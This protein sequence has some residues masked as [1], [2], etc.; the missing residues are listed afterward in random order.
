LDY[1]PHSREEIIEML[2]TVGADSVGELIEKAIP[3]EALLE[4]DLNLPAPL[5][6]QEA[7]LLIEEL[8]QKNAPLNG[9]ASFLGAGVYN[10][11]IPA[12]VKAVIEKPEFFTAYTPYQPEVSQG[13]LASIFE[14]Q[15]MIC[16]LTGMDA[17]NASMYDGA[18]ATAEAV[19]MARRI[20]KKKG[21]GSVIVLEPINPFYLKVLEA[22][23][24]PHGIRIVLCPHNRGI[25]EF[26][27][28]KEIL[29]Q[30]EDAFAV[31][32]PE[33]SFYGTVY[34]Y[35]DFIAL[36]KEQGVLSIVVH[37]PHL[38]S[39]LEPPGKLGADICTGEAQP[40]GNPLNFGG[41]LLGYLATREEFLRQLPGRIVGESVDVEGNRVFV[42]TLQTREQHIRREKATSNICTNEALCALAAT[43]Y[44]S[45]FGPEGMKKLSELIFSKTMYAAVEL[46]KHFELPYEKPFFK[47]FVVKLDRN[48]EEVVRK[49]IAE[50]IIPGL[51]VA[52]IDSKADPR[53]LMISVTEL[54][55]RESIDRLISFLKSEGR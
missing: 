19:L 38:L 34:D 31:V 14:F 51:P 29:D 27:R 47:D 32:I 25:P 22:Y 35:R 54:S 42:M 49:G 17:A 10:H 55:S 18:T 3:R 15:T 23:L 9:Y 1:I 46:E 41:P 50:K 6:E 24:E 48:A 21:D 12:V 40:L 39:L 11:Y 52:S 13:T 5:S 43:V 28:F 20:S 2:K 30:F 44:M 53:E 33:P 26:N 7:S 16:E 8:S 45:W 36:S 37:E 4:R